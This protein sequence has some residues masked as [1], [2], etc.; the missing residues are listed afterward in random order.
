MLLSTQLY[1]L[2]RVPRYQFCQSQCSDGLHNLRQY[3][4]AVDTFVA[5][6]QPI[7]YF[8]SLQYFNSFQADYNTANRIII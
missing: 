3:P 2:Q 4:S 7:L 8:I 1:S 5:L 6:K